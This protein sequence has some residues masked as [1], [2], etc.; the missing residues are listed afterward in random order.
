MMGVWQIIHGNCWTVSM[1]IDSLPPRS[2]TLST[3][4][5]IPDEFLLC[6]VVVS[7]S[8]FNPITKNLHIFWYNLFQFSQPILHCHQHLLLQLLLTNPAWFTLSWNRMSLTPTQQEQPVIQGSFDE[9]LLAFIFL[10]H[11]LLLLYL[12]IQR[13]S[14]LPYVCIE[15]HITSRAAHHI[16]IPVITMQNSTQNGFSGGQGAI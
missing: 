14:T 13:H 6:T 1:S 8:L 12:F 11:Q 9:S 10:F 16:Y 5:E 4:S 3:T 7:V 15:L 2:I